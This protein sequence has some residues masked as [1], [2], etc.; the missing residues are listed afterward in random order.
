MFLFLFKGI[1]GDEATWTAHL[2][3]H[4]SVIDA[5]QTLAASGEG[6]DPEVGVDRIA[7]DG[8]A[9]SELKFAAAAA[10]EDPLPEVPNATAAVVQMLGQLCQGAPGVYSARMGKLP[11]EKGDCLAKIFQAHG[12]QVV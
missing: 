3:S 7:F 10:A 4:V 9:Y 2:S 8:D 1:K 6:D 11:Q 12:V 5:G